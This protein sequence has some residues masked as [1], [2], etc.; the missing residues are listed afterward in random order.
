L[1]M[2]AQILTSWRNKL[3]KQ[4]KFRHYTVRKNIMVRPRGHRPMPP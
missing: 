1:L 4:S 3:V 2:D